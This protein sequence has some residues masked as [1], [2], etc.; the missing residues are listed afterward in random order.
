[1]IRPLLAFEFG[2]HRRQPATIVAALLLFALGLMFA[3]L[4]GNAG[5]N[6]AAPWLIAYSLGILSLG[7]VLAAAVLAGP[8]LLRDRDSHMAPIV[9][10]TGITRFDY[11]LSRF[12][13]MLGMAAAIY[14]LAGLGMLL[15][16]MLTGTATIRTPIDIVRAL[17]VIVLPNVLVSVVVLF[18]VAAMTRSSAA[19]WIAGAALYMLYFIGSLLGNSPL[20]AHSAERAPGE[21]RAGLLLDPYGLIAFLEQTRLWSEAE[22]N[23]RALPLDGPLLINR[24]LWIALSLALV[25]A[26]ALRFRFRRAALRRRHSAEAPESVETEAAIPPWRPVTVRNG[27]SR[28]LAPAVWVHARIA[29]HASIFRA[30]LLVLMLLWLGMTAISLIETVSRG[31]LG[32]SMQ[33]GAGLLAPLL[34]EALMNLGWLVVALFAAELAWQARAHGMQPVVQAVP[35][36]DLATFIG[37]LLALAVLIAGLVLAGVACAVGLHWGM[38]AASLD[39]ARYL[40]LL[41]YAGLPLLLFGGLALLIQRAAPNRYAGLLFS[42]CVPLTVALLNRLSG[43]DRTILG[44]SAFPDYVVSDLAAR[45]YHAD[46]FGALAL[47]WGGLGVALVIWRFGRRRRLSAAI[48]AL[49]V[50]VSLGH[51]AWTHQRLTPIDP[52]RFHAPPLEWA[53]ARER[54]W[55]RFAALPSPTAEQVRLDVALFPDQRR[56]RVSGEIDL[57]HQGD[58]SIDRVVVGLP[59]QNRRDGALELEGATLKRWDKRFGIG[60]YEFTTPL[61]T[62]AS[63]QLRFTLEVQRPGFALLNPENYL[64]GDVA[65]IEVDKWIPYVGYTGRYELTEARDRADFGLPE[66]PASDRAAPPTQSRGISLDLTVSVPERHV[67]V[68]IGRVAGSRVEDG[69]RI[70]HFRSTEAIRDR[71]A[72]AS[73]P[74]RVET[75]VEDGITIEQ[76]LRDADPKNH[77]E[78]LAGARGSLAFHHETIDRYPDPV[79]RLVTL[80]S[81]S[82]AFGGTAYAGTVFLVDNR[83]LQARIDGPVPIN[84][85]FSIAA[86]EVAHQWWGRKLQPADGP[87]YRFLTESLAKWSE[88]EI[89]RRTRGEAVADDYRARMRG[90]YFRVRAT[91]EPALIDVLDDPAAFYFKGAQALYVIG[92]RLGRERLLAILREFAADFAAPR[93]ARAAE[94]ARRLRAAANP[95]DS[96]EIRELLEQVVIHDLALESATINHAGKS[97]LADIV[98]RHNAKRH[99]ADGAVFPYRALRTVELAALDEHGRTLAH[100]E[101]RLR[102]ER[103]RIQWRLDSRPAVLALDPR[104]LLLEPDESDN[105]IV[106]NP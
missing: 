3:R 1:M 71:Y 66:R 42:A 102:N 19:A 106:L 93:T 32:V 63:V 5:P 50:T 82:D 37:E 29:L 54:E 59:V 85:A 56:Y 6:P 89:I 46:A 44:R 101:I 57:A 51:G 73:A 41:Y 65:Y 84:P 72:V 58:E 40:G 62:G 68:S 27:P 7:S 104:G 67:P 21:L 69:R 47:F 94:L 96:D 61:D 90:A 38:G 4:N 2:L 80:P 43:L 31:E 24:L 23:I 12:G 34:H 81:F 76:Y 49:L 9:F 92:E 11:L 100:R 64:V 103:T 35:A 75:T 60:E 13:G 17:V 10:A 30:P 25:T 105:R 70:T 83:A 39:L 95:A 15:G 86:H 74:Y 99:G 26:V 48:A 36:P 55:G 18:T 8:A 28:L 20:M 14:L 33:P 97:F 45:P 78:A 87:G 53:A 91:P 98:V 16:Y 88:L 52:S 22:R 79:L 77:H